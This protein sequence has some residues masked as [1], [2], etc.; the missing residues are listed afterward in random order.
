MHQQRHSES[1]CCDCPKPTSKHPES[2]YL[3][4]EVK[5][6]S[7]K[8]GECLSV[9]SWLPVEGYRAT[10]ARP[11]LPLLPTIP[12][13]PV[14]FW[15]RDG[16]SPPVHAAPHGLTLREAALLSHI[17][18]QPQDACAESNRDTPLEKACRIQTHRE[19]LVCLCAR[20]EQHVTLAHVHTQPNAEAEIPSLFQRF[21]GQMLKVGLKMMQVAAAAFIY[22]SPPHW[23]RQSYHRMFAGS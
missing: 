10:S 18:L 3:T 20:R 2:S 6:R 4:A 9:K 23:C 7:H 15:I 13:L 5:H 17:N 1:Q 8:L 22:P 14:Q 11:D 21:I 16:L 19:A 12:P